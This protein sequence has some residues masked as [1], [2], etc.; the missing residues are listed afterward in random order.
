MQLKIENGEL[1]MKEMKRF[2]KV[3][4]HDWNQESKIINLKLFIFP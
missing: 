3:V 4:L 1:K 2:R